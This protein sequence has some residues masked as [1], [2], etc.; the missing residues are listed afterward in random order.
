MKSLLNYHILTDNANYQRAVSVVDVLDEF[1]LSQVGN[2][3]GNH[4]ADSLEDNNRIV[5]VADSAKGQ[6]FGFR[7]AIVAAFIEV[8]VIISAVE[9]SW[10][11]L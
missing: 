8:V 1:G 3:V 2:I 7:S 9:E 5:T 11:C 10:K 4:A 6:A